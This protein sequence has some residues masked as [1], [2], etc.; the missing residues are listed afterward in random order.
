MN[1]NILNETIINDRS[2]NLNPFLIIATAGTTDTGSIDPLIAIASIA[3]TNT[4]WLHVD[5][6]YGGFFKLTQH[7][8]NHLSGMSLADSITLDPHK[9]LFLPYGIGAV[10]IKNGQL[11]KQTFA[12]TASYMQDIVT[13]SDDW[14]PSDMSP[15]LTKHFRA[16]RMW[17]P[18]KYYGVEPFKHALDEK[19]LLA[20]FFYTELKKL[21]H[22]QFACMPELSIVT[23]RYL[24][25]QGD[26][27]A[28]NKALL[29][30]INHDKRI[31]LSSTSIDGNYFIRMACLSFRTH[32]EDILLTLDIIKDA[33]CILECRSPAIS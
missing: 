21:N 16:L 24:P 5:A 13:S 32:L 27:N 22:I 1:A 29:K 3:S 15:E 10:L 20:Q 25:E 14:S 23:F 26:A 12:S 2:N 6:A 28:F 11:Q 4:M 7:G 30:S 17:M 18:L 33:I 9:G 31:F 19:L 8:E